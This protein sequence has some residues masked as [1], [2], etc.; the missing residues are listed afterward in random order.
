MQRL[1]PVRRSGRPCARRALHLFAA[2]LAV[3]LSVPGNATAAG[4]QPADDDTLVWLDDYQQALALAKETGRP[5]LLEFRC[6][7]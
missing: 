5:L 3:L 6:A 7:P 4:G 1:E 2:C